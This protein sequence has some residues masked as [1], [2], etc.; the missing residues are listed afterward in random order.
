[1]TDARVEQFNQRIDRHLVERLRRE[2]A[3]ALKMYR[4]LERT[5]EELFAKLLAFEEKWGASR[6]FT[7]AYLSA[8]LDDINQTMAELRAEAVGDLRTRMLDGYH[9]GA[10]QTFRE[11][12][13][14][15]GGFTGQ[16]APRVPLEVITT[17]IEGQVGLMETTFE[18]LRLRLVAQVREAT[19]YSLGE[20]EASRRA[21]ATVDEIRARLASGIAQ[22]EGSQAIAR[23]LMAEGTGDFVRLG[24]REAI[25]QTRLNLND[26]FNHGHVQALIQAKKTVPGLRQRWVS[27]LVRSTPVCLCLHGQ[28]ADVG[29]TFQVSNSFGGNW[30]GMRPPA[31]GQGA[32]PVV[33]L[34]RSRV[35]PDHPE[36]PENRKLVPLNAADRRHFH[37][38]GDFRAVDVARRKV[39]PGSSPRADAVGPD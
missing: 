9:L 3:A 35:V 10:E 6:T 18:R 39:Y 14:W 22:G 29:G 27:A 20:A 13:V 37:E 36:W 1:M 31:I 5:R 32:K 28:V 8:I 26:A 16:L 15:Y 11:V 19:A 2:D 24:Y 33:H 30:R 12:A 34:C 17:I 38:G 7:P 4:M 21:A 25:L 23:R